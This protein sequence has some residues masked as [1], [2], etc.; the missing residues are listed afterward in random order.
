MLAD[1]DGVESQGGWWCGLEAGLRAGG[2]HSVGSVVL[3]M[4]RLVVGISVPDQ[5]WR[6][7]G[8]FLCLFVLYGSPLHW[9]RPMH[10]FSPVC[11]SRWKL[12][13]RPTCKECLTSYL[14]QV[15]RT[16]KFGI[17][18][19]LS[20]EHNTRDVVLCSHRTCWKNHPRK[21]T[22]VSHDLYLVSPKCQHFAPIISQVSSH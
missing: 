22:P 5:A 10:L 17:A 14:G 21:L 13:H 11:Q 4:G 19:G 9:M 12:P 3:S 20:R 2:V 1:L 8:P 7:D 15:K 6:M 16:H 18:V